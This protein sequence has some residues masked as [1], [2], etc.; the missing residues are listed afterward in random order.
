MISGISTNNMPKYSKGIN[1][2]LKDN[3]DRVSAHFKG[4]SL[5]IL[6]GYIVTIPRILNN[7]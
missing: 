5:N 4:I 3:S 1:L 6:I 2:F 7:K